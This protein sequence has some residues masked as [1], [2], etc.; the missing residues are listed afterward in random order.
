MSCQTDF[1][2]QKI[3]VFQE[4]YDFF[5]IFLDFSFDKRKKRGIVQ[6]HQDTV[7]LYRGNHAYVAQLVEHFL[8]KEEVSGSNP[9]IGSIFCKKIR[10]FN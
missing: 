4:K 10:T 9:D 5:S 1:Y 6:S 3:P 7:S 2:E 8:G